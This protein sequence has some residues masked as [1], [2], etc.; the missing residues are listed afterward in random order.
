MLVEICAN[1]YVSAKHAQEGGAHRIELCQELS[2]GGITP[3][4]GLI[5]QVVEELSIPVFVLIRP[6]SGHFVYSKE[7]IDIML[8]DIKVCQSLGCSGIVSGALNSNKTIDLDQTKKLMDASGNMSFTFHRAF[9][10]V[11]NPEESLQ[12]LIDLGVNRV[13]SSGQEPTALKGLEVLKRL[14]EQAQNQI[15]IMPG[16]GINETNIPCFVNAGFKEVHTSA[17]VYFQPEEGGFF[18][19]DTQSVTSL[20]K[21]KAIMDV[22]RKS[23]S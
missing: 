18:S 22:I 12:Q 20:E 23:N 8:K 1:S 2:V 15:T 3:S 11:A 10:E 13:L 16:A 9:D 17:S 19:K 6:R 7:E 5:Q 14:K 21:V 4:Y